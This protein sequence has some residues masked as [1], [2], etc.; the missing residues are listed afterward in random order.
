M[1]DAFEAG[2]KSLPIR[3]R[4]VVVLAFPGVNLLDISGPAEV[5]SCLEEIRGEAAY[6]VNVASTTDDLR[7]RTSSGIAVAA[8]HEA[9]LV[10]EPPRT[11][12]VPGGA[13]VWEAS[14]DP[15]TID[16]VRRLAG[17]ADRVASVCTGTFLL[18]AAGLLD[19]LR[20]TTHWRWC[21]R[22]REEYP[23]VTV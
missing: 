2:S 4:R 20:A 16:L 3:R 11:L 8:D 1:R 22:L 9:S 13:G 21:E 14:R 7:V 6:S 10:C 12:V 23:A 18:A 19:G 17:L 5:F 15:K